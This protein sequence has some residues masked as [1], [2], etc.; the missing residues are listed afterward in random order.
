VG[1]FAVLYEALLEVPCVVQPV[2]LCEVFSAVPYAG[3]SEEPYVA[4]LE[5]PYA[6][7]PVENEVL[8]AVQLDVQDEVFSEVSSEVLPVEPYVGL[9]AEPYVVQLEAPCVVPGTVLDPM[10]ILQML[11]TV[12]KPLTDQ[13]FSFLSPNN[14]F[15]SFILTNPKKIVKVFL[16]LFFSLK[17]TSSVKFIHNF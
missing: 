9:S 8:F 10:Q 13:S 4:L 17:M 5:V 6:V 11:I 2:A 12:S 14:I 7:Q 15:L 16:G 3:L 1:L